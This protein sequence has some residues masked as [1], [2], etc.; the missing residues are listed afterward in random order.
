MHCGPKE[1]K[2][3]LADIEYI[4]SSLN[5][6]VKSDCTKYNK[7]V[8]WIDRVELIGSFLLSLLK[9]SLKL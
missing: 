7:I 6:K 1:E 3:I 4:Y 5:S 8:S 9:V 2:K